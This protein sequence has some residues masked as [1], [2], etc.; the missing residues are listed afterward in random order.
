MVSKQLSLSLLFFL[1]FVGLGF[2]IGWV[3]TYEYNPGPVIFNI[4]E[5][6]VSI[7]VINAVG[8][9]NLWEPGTCI[10]DPR[11]SNITLAY[12]RFDSPFQD[13]VVL[14]IGESADFQVR[15]QESSKTVIILI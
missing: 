11:K 1:L 5:E 4:E 7:P 13:Y 9:Q 14:K 6:G 12:P 2:S 8:S 3:P 15:E 10:V